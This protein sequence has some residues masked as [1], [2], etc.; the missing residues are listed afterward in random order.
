[1]KSSS[2][3]QGKSHVSPIREGVSEITCPTLPSWLIP[4]ILWPLTK[5][6][7]SDPQPCYR[8][9]RHSSFLKKRLTGLSR[10]TWAQRTIPLPPSEGGLF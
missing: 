9:D 2:V 3:P 10:P 4:R 8:R 7:N 6:L 5:N 1:M